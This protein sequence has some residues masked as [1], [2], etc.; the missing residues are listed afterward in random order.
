MPW[1]RAA[2][3]AVT[4]AALA[5][6]AAAFTPGGRVSPLRRVGNAAPVRARNAGRRMSMVADWTSVLH[7]NP[8]TACAVSDWLHMHAHMA[9]SAACHPP[10]DGGLVAHLKDAAGSTFDAYNNAL[11]TDY[12]RTTA[13]QALVLVGL[14]D[15][16]AQ[17]FEAR[18]RRADAEARE[19]EAVVVATIDV[20]GEVKKVACV[21]EGGDVT[22]AAVE[23][24]EW[25]DP[26]RTLRMGFL[27]LVIGGLGTSHWLQ[28]LEQQLP[29]HDHWQT[30]VQK[31]M[32][33]GC[34]W[35]PIANTAYLIFTPLLEGEDLDFVKEKLAN[36]FVPVMIAELSTFLPYNLVSFSMIPPLIRPFSTGF[37]SMCFAIY[38]SMV[39]HEAEDAVDAAVES[40]AM[41]SPQPRPSPQPTPRPVPSTISG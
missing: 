27:G 38:L 37:L 41:P 30:I 22:C 25:F 21:E 16:T 4:V 34:I 39:S 20:K 36:R 28:Y 19:K 3:A 11:Q 33:D 10:P 14:G 9:P 13:I 7:I 6:E 40:A 18:N 31:A 24:E 35:A 15:V 26:K 5:S 17:F 2:L 32:L 23:V 1:M 8:Q 12:D 29:G